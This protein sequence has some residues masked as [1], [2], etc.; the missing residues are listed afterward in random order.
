MIEY[1]N[2]TLSELAGILDW[3]AQE[4]WNPGLDDAAAFFAAD[5]EGFFVA[6]D[7]DQPVGAV[8]V[9]NHSADFAFLGLYLV[10]PERRGEGLGLALW[11]HAMVHAGKRVVGLDGVPDQQGNYVKSG[12]VKAGG[13]T[14]YSGDIPG[15]AHGDIAHAT[16]RDIAELIDREAG[17][18]GTRKPAYLGAWF[19]AT[20]T[21]LTLVDRGKDGMHGFCTVRKCAKGVKI[22]PLV[23]R[24]KESAQRLLEHAAQVFDGPVILDVPD[25]SRDLAILCQSYSL[26]P[27][28]E[29]ARMYRG[30]APKAPNL[31]P[32]F[33]VTSL[34]LG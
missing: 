29:T 28:F 14:R 18:S 30:E 22:G 5:S 34:E 23:A 7:G 25:A 20:A 12:F 27:S 13:T 6:C 2:A 11:R 19:T 8:S 31:L 33:A 16:S 32:Y 17:A 21:R 15:R 10:V 26:S 4:G 1:R 24:D 9:V 3:A